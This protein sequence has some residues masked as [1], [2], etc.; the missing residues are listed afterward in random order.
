ME[1][2][3]FKKLVEDSV[4]LNAETQPFRPYKALGKRIFDVFLAILLLPSIVPVVLTLWLL[5]RLDGGQGFFGHWR[6]GKNGKEFRCWKIRTMVANAEAALEEHLLENPEAR[7]E[8]ERD[9]KLDNDPRITRLGKFLR[10]TS[11]DEL[12]QIW[13]VVRGEM[14]FV[15]A[16]PIVR[17]ELVRYGVHAGTYLSMTPGITGLWQVSGRNDVS[18]VQ[19]VEMDV[20]YAETCSLWQDISI[21]FRTGS[22]VLMRTGK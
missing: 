21:I 9:F 3:D 15:G 7:A 11:L 14:S 12:P 16:R 10:K 22:S 18:Y 2:V 1:V 13:N 8:W 6:V 20:L 19:R 5:T 4:A 17:D